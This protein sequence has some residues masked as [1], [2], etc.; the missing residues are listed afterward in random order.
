MYE[1]FKAVPHADGSWSGNAGAVWNLNSNALRPDAWT[2]AD[3]AGF[4]VYPALVKFAE[5]EAGVIPHA[6]RF[7]APRARVRDTWVWPARHTDGESTNPLDPPMGT[8]FRLKQS[9]DIS[10]TPYQL[11]VVLQA[12]KDYGMFLSDT[13]MA[14]NVSGAPDER[15]DNTVLHSIEAIYG[16]DLE[17]VDQNGLMVDPN[18]GQSR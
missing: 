14:W 5:V 8:R 15:W 3:A 6:L 16:R 10:Q 18:S 2:S 9:V 12:L 7:T 11:R 4:A 13:G 17:V 1:V